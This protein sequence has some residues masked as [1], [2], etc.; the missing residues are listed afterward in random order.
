MAE[1][2]VLNVLET[3][4]PCTLPGIP[5]AARRMIKASFMQVAWLYGWNG[6]PDKSVRPHHS[7]LAHK[8]FACSLC[9]LQGI[10][11]HTVS[12]CFISAQNAT[13]CLQC[14]G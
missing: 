14:A 2:G 13:P 9:M 8:D 4:M 6:V 1:S 3:Q 5:S 11:S 7:G 10:E 12:T